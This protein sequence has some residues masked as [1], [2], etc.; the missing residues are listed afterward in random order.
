[1]LNLAYL[2]TLDLLFATNTEKKAIEKFILFKTGCRTLQ[3]A[4]EFIVTNPDIGFLFKK[5]DNV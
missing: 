3:E 5:I 1:V 2:E 4:M